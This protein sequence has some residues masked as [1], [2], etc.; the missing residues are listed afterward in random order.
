MFNKSE[1]SGLRKEINEAQIKIH[2]LRQV[3]DE[4]LV[5]NKEKDA[6]IAKLKSTQNTAHGI[7]LCPFCGEEAAVI[8]DRH[9]EGGA[10]YGVVCLNGYCIMYD[11]IPCYESPI[12]AFDAWNNRMK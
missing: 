9:S 11:V 2:E 1:V 7:S 5:S 8:V 12:S 6:E 3:R 10:R 4:L